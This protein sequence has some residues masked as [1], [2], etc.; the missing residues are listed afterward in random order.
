MNAHQWTLDLL[1]VIV[2]SALAA[3][4]I[5]VFGITATPIRLAL[6][7]PLVLLWP[8]Y[9]FISA[10]FPEKPAE[11]KGFDTLER[12]VLSVALSLV[13]V[14]IIAYLANFTPY[15]I[16]LTPITVGVVVWT[17][18]FAVLGLLRRARLAS[19]DRYRLRWTGTTVTLPSLFS[20]QERGLE[21][22]RDPFEPE[23]GRHILLNVVLV[24]SILVLAVGGAYMTVA[25]PSLPDTEAHT[26]AYL[27]TQNESGEFVADDLPTEFSS[28]STQPVYLGIENHEGET[29]TYTTVVLQQNVT[30]TDNGST[31]A[32]V[33]SEEELG[34]FQT[35]VANG[36]TTR[37]EYGV[38]PTASGDAHIW[39]LVYPGDVPDDPSPEN[40]Q[41]ATR[42]SV[43][44]S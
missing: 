41:V 32:S 27:L 36:E 19:E 30:L 6:A 14:S 44:V 15:G 39:F 34:R 28:G 25:A 11:D 4:G 17:I 31:V 7:V 37:T 8:G 35:T 38:T 20:L 10:L 3:A 42:L 13:V 5:L 12:V 21:G 9:A 1:V 23:N 18:T 40:A 29:R 16:R 43:T 2:L 22:R 33:N 24:G 26:E